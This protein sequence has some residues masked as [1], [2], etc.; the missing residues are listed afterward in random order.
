MKRELGQCFTEAT[1]AD[2]L[3]KALPTNVKG[4]HV[5]EPS[6]GDGNLIEAVLQAG[7]AKVTAIEIDPNYA[8]ALVKRYQGDERVLIVNADFIEWSQPK[9]NTLFQLD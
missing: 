9:K 3:L 2:K 5:L 8:A 6:A 7:A 4:K 1:L